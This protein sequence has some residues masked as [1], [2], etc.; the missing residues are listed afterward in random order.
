[1]HQIYKNAQKYSLIDVLNIN[2]R[3]LY[4]L[5]KFS[6]ISN[7]T[8]FISLDPIFGYL[9][10]NTD[11]FDRE[12]IGNWL[13]FT[14]QVGLSTSNYYLEILDRND[15]LPHFI[16]SA[17]ELID[18]EEN[19]NENSLIFKL[20]AVDGDKK[21]K[22]LYKILT[23]ENNCC[24]NLYNLYADGDEINLNDTSYFYLNENTG[25]LFTKKTIDFEKNEQFQIYFKAIDP[26]FDYYNNVKKLED[27]DRTIFKLNI[28]IV[29]INDNL[30]QFDN[31]TKSFYYL[32]LIFNQLK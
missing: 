26:E 32:K 28:R 2:D 17:E 5:V 22:V 8:N 25:E 29:D 1:M 24:N 20:H 3:S 6:F 15:N 31:S 19:L 7:N 18:L 23:R 10:V 4:G 16:D 12:L 13:N 30:P 11:T 27:L 9:Q 14:V 21:S